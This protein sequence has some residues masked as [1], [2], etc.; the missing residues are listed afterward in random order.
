MSDQGNTNAATG[1]STNTQGGNAQGTNTGAGNANG[2]AAPWF[3]TFQTPENRGYAE[4][5]G[6]KDAESVVESYRNLEKL[7]GVP[8]E[9]LLRLPDKLDDDKAL[10]EIYNKLGR[11]EKAD[12]YEVKVPEGADPEF[13]NW[14]K[15]LFHEAGLTKRQGDSIAAKWN[16]RMAGALKAHQDAE[17]AAFNSQVENLKKE[18]GAAYDQ[19]LGQAKK[20]ATAMGLDE[21]QAEKMSRVVGVDGFFKMIHG[22]QAKFGIKL[23]EAGFKGEGGQGFGQILSPEGARARINELKSDK[24]FTARLHNGDT[25]ARAEWDRVH[26]NLVG[27]A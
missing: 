24:E 14:A 18:W 6:F 3:S 1:D 25:A 23:D 10:S 11:P 17:D 15:G 4:S 12:G 20:L 9:K 5:K 7:H 21:E 8:K 19:N 22:L 16:E 27:M 13:G 2:Q 26:R